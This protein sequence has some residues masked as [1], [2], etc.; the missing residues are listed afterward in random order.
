MGRVSVT[1]KAVCVASAAAIMFLGMAGLI[2]GQPVKDPQPKASTRATPHAS[3][4][5]NAMSTMS[6]MTIQYLEIVTPDV[7]ATCQVLGRAHGVEF[8]EPIPALG[9]ART[10]DLSGGGRISV[11]APMRDSESPVVRPYVL[12]EDI[13]AALAEARAAGAEIAMNA[14]ELP[15]QGSFAI[16]ILGGIQHGLWQRLLPSATPQPEPTNP[17]ER[18]TVTSLDGNA[19]AFLPETHHGAWSGPNR[20]WMTDPETPFHSEGTVNIAHTSITYTWAHEGTEHRGEITLR[21]QPEALEATWTDSWHAPDPMI[22]H[23][24]REGGRTTLYGIY[25]AGKDVHWGWQ[26]ELDT[27]DRESFVLR[28]RNVVPGIGPVPAVVLHGTR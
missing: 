10:A 9:N 4:T 28:M 27:E 11:R 6:T 16:Y 18:P 14:T 20:L 7:D 22:L 24:R 3:T 17:Q 1:A 13:D 2:H 15:G 23:G 5:E 21:G 25:P 12:V 26:I 19:T 8:S